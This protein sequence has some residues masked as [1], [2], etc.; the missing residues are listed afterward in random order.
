[1]QKIANNA[2][3]QPGGATPNSKN[4]LVLNNRRNKWKLVNLQRKDKTPKI[5]L[6]KLS[7]SLTPLE[8]GERKGGQ[9]PLKPY[10]HS[11]TDPAHRKRKTAWCLKHPKNPRCEKS[12]N[13]KEGPKNKL[14]KHRAKKYGPGPKSRGHFLTTRRTPLEKLPQPNEQKL[15]HS[16]RPLGKFFP[17]K[18]LVK[19]LLGTSMRTSMR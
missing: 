10:T 14:S 1:M 15:I 17:L 12:F 11:W 6:K 13:P 2:I 4:V 8:K 3:R 18:S 5:G 9:Q 16:L 19:S 7:A